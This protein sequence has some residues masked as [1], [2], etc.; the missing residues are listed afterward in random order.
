MGLS[1]VVHNKLNLLCLTVM[2]LG[3]LLRGTDI[4]IFR[5]HEA[6]KGLQKSYMELCNMYRL[7]N[8]K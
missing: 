7:S 8:M 5:S 4:L 2:K 6:T 3:N 1:M